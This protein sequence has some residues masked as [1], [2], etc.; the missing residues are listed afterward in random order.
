MN[1]PKYTPVPELEPITALVQKILPLVYDDSL[2]YYEVLCKVPAIVNEAFQNMD[3]N[4]EI[5]NKIDALVADGTITAIVKEILEPILKKTKV[6]VTDNP[7]YESNELNYSDSGRENSWDLN[8][9]YLKP[10]ATIESIYINALSRLNSNERNKK[11]GVLC[12]NSDNEFSAVKGGFNH[13][14]QKSLLNYI[15]GGLGISL[16]CLQE[17]FNGKGFEISNYLPTISNVY[18]APSIKNMYQCGDDLGCVSFGMSTFCS[19][20]AQNKYSVTLTKPEPQ[21]ENVISSFYEMYYSGKKFIICNVH[22]GWAGSYEEWYTQMRELR[23]E[24]AKYTR[25]SDYHVIVMGDFNADMGNPESEK[26]YKMLYDL[27]LKSLYTNKKLCEGGTITDGRTVDNIFISNNLE[28]EEYNMPNNTFDIPFM[29]DH[30]PI[31]E[32]INILD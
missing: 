3:F 22:M 10:D 14:L 21:F 20:S 23:D 13:K 9:K 26:G 27:G 1:E 30:K 15:I 28:F 18:F 4:T 17:T 6:S 29:G 24:L 12:Y 7:V 25:V 32:Y 31:V 2:S 19:S 16:A 11:I 5:S 8:K